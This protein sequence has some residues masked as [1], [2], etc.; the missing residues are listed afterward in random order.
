MLL[1]LTRSLDG[2]AVLQLRLDLF[3]HQFFD[4]DT[5]A[6]CFSHVLPMHLAELLGPEH[7]VSIHR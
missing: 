3:G 2:A 6:S 5:T 7:F 1:G 4:G